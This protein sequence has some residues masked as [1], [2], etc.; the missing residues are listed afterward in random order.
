MRRST[1]LSAYFSLL[2]A[3]SAS[4]LVLAIALSC[5][6]ATSPNGDAAPALKY[7]EILVPDSIKNASGMTPNMV[8][9]I[10]VGVAPAIRSSVSASSCGS[11]V[12]GPEY[13]F[14]HVAFAPEAAPAYRILVPPTAA[15]GDGYTPNVPLGFQFDFYGNSYDK[16]NVFANG[17]V[18]FGATDSAT[19]AAS[20]GWY[21]ADRIPYAANPNNLI[22]LAWTDWSPQRAG[23][24]AI[25]YETRGTAPNRR[26]IL[27]FT[28]VPEYGTYSVMTVQLVLAEGSNEVTIYT[29][30]M[31]VSR[32]DHLVTQGIENAGGTLAAFDSVQNPVLLSWAPRVRNFFKLSNDVVRF[33][34]TVVKD[35]VNPSITAPDNITQ[36]NDP[37]LASAVVAVGSP[38]AADNCSDVTLSSV[39]S[40]GA[41][42]DAPYPVGVTTITWTATDASGNTAWA[43]QTVTVLDVEAP[44]FPM[45]RLSSNL[46]Y[47][48]TSPAGATVTYTVAVSDNVGVTSLTCEPASGSVFPVGSTLVSCVAGDAAGNSSSHSFSVNV[49]GPH[50]QLKSLLQIVIDYNLPNGTAQPLINQLRAAYREPGSGEAT[51]KK[52]ADFILL[53]ERK[54]SSISPE[55]AAYVIAEANRIMDALGCDSGSATSGS[56]ARLTY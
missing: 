26:F 34:P 30:S 55:V 39:R 14:S 56:L 54:Q 16:V 21:R 2:R 45:T 1:S 44:V 17:L 7:I 35:V 9:N 40:D 46:G 27:Q 11:G 19:I 3:G 37:G 24:D 5:S 42:I 53:V 47:N 31:T 10:S 22:A 48:A 13:T 18:T 6:D 50:E 29:P 52:L 38:V 8:G 51:C 33:T 28:K 36:G 15:G 41:A 20:Y 12:T 32:I 23:P 49:I 25:R 4:A 43:T